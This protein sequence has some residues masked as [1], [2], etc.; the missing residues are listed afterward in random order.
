MTTDTKTVTV[1]GYEL[2]RDHILSA[3]VG[4]NEEDILYWCGKEIARKFPLLELDEVTD[5]FTE[6]SW[7]HLIL[8]KTSKSEAF[9]SLTGDADI[10][11]FDQ[12]SFRLEAGY[13]AEQHQK[14]NGF[15]TECHEEVDTKKNTV[16]FHIKWDRKDPIH[17]K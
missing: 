4:K 2:L 14:Y 1:F 7:G 15:L 5:F 9:Y 17:S 13:L 11:K 16:N 8:D 10:L 3:I 6:A 12:R